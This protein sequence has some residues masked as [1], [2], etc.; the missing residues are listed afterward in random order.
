[1]TSHSWWTTWRTSIAAELFSIDLS[2][3]ESRERE[4]ILWL[5]E[6]EQERWKTLRS[7]SRR[8]EFVLGRGAVRQ[9]ICERLKVRNDQL[10]FFNDEYG[11]PRIRVNKRSVSWQ[12]NMSH[13]QPYGLL[14]LVNGLKVG[15]D[16]E[17]RKPRDDFDAMARVVFTTPERR[18]LVNLSDTQK[19]Y[20][21]Y[22]MWCL[23]EALI[24]GIGKGFS[25]NPSTIEIPET[26]LKGAKSGLWQT[27]D[28]KGNVSSWRM[29][30]LSQPN[31]AASVAVEDKG[32]DENLCL[33]EGSCWQNS[34]WT[35]KRRS[36]SILIVKR[37]RFLPWIVEDE[38]KDRH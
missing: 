23:K 4:A 29:A 21:F 33:Y 9:I 22:R 8:Q 24:K 25:I 13:S 38:K 34:I 37:Y 12:F 27:T 26:M 6:D 1:M 30:D 35:E 18:C 7:P 16:I 19:R 2:P 5:D 28:Q 36:K 15:I 10:T 14:A 31:F 3:N 11:K 20:Q 17:V 32:A